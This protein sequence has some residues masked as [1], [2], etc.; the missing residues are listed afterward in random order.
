MEELGGR[1][2]LESSE[3]EFLSRMNDLSSNISDENSA[4]KALKFIGSYCGFILLYQPEDIHFYDGQRLSLKIIR[5]CLKFCK[6]EKIA[7]YA[8]KGCPGCLF[9][10]ILLFCGMSPKLNK[11][12]EKTLGSFLGNSKLGQ[13]FKVDK[14]IKMSITNYKRKNDRY[15]FMGNCLDFGMESEFV[16]MCVR[17][18][19]LLIS[20]KVRKMVVDNSPEIESLIQNFINASSEE[21][22]ASYSKLLDLEIS[23]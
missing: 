22:I 9:L 13:L 16:K 11:D 1:Q 5:K 14:L 10:N 7:E 18:G 4:I 15:P 3:E 8:P 20:E 12:V 19:N 23:H 17:Y 21:E 2:L 6:G